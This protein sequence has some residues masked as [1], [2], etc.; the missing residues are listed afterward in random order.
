MKDKPT[1]KTKAELLEML[2]EAVRNTQPQSPTGT[3]QAD[4]VRDVQPKLNKARSAAKRTTKAKSARA[5]GQRKEPR[6]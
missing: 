5:P 6:R 4:P 2:A 1:K 3:T